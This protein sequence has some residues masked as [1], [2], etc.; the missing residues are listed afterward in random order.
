M[1]NPSFPQGGRFT[2]CYEKRTK[3]YSYLIIAEQ[4][5]EEENP[6]T[7]KEQHLKVQET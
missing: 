5:L 3:I 1:I 4:L 2:L 7:S 6:T